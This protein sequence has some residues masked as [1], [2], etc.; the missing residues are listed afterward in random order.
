MRSEPERGAEL[1]DKVVWLL[2]TDRFVCLLAHKQ[3]QRMDE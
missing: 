3:P 2:F 1:E